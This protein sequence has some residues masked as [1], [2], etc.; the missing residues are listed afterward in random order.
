MNN[1]VQVK[2]HVNWIITRKSMQWWHETYGQDNFMK[3]NIRLSQYIDT[4][5][6]IGKGLLHDHLFN[7]KPT[8]QHKSEMWGNCPLTPL[9]SPYFP[10][11]EQKIAKIKHLKKKK[12]TDLWP[13]L[14]QNAL[15]PSMSLYKKKKKFS[16]AATDFDQ[17]FIFVAKIWTLVPKK[18]RCKRQ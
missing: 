4:S 5:K 10:T 16:V 13:L 3:Q 6:C 1:E 8:F 11:W 18:I 14:C 15:C 12:E 7:T 2:I 9:L 17:D